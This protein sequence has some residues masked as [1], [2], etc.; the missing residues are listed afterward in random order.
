VN[1]FDSEPPDPPD[2][3]S[4]DEAEREVLT[5][6]HHHPGRLRVRA[7]TFR[8]GEAANRVQ[9]AL[10]MEPGIT[11][12]SHNA[13]TGSLLI[14]YQPG[15]AEPESILYAIAEAAGL[16]MPSDDGGA[17]R[18]EPALVAIDTVREVNSIVHEVTGYRADLRTIV[19]AGMAALAAYSFVANREARLPRWD[20][21][22]YWS[23]NIFSQLH[24]REIDGQQGAD[25]SAHPQ[26]P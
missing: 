22:L 6:V 12:V 16:E 24:R 14:E 7:T 23:Y 1:T 5:L 25:A 10:D 26:R 4:N 17:R 13:K 2:P 8:E 21:L 18:R 11:A 15:L 9:R 20:N 3:S 19:P